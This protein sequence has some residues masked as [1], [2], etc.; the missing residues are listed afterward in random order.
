M[1]RILFQG[2]SIT[3][4]NCRQLLGRPPF[5]PVQDPP[6]PGYGDIL[7]RNIL[8]TGYPVIVSGELNL[9][10]PGELLF[11]NRA[12]S[13]ARIV[14]IYANIKADI[15]NLKPDVLSILLGVN[16]V[17]HEV[18]MKNGVDAE[19][20]ERVYRQLLA[21]ITEALPDLRI[22]LMEPYVL[23]GYLT[24]DH[25][26]EFQAEVRKRAEAVR[27]IAADRGLVLAETQKEMNRY[28]DQYGSEMVTMDGIHPTCAGS[29]LLAHA[30]MEGFEKLT[31]LK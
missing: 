12:M 4:M 20:F 21:E 13:G 5:P 2:D 10:H 1:I 29:A 27:R 31:G 19:K 8:G 24:R 15:I 30:W 26:E 3:D 9:K 11:M 22:I 7:R 25:W 17:A 16:D 14:D 28:A 18:T 23:N 6:M